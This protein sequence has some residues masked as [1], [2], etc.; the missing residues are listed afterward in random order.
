MARR[1]S[2]QEEQ[3]IVEYM[4]ANPQASVRSVASRF[5]RSRP[6]IDSLRSRYA[7]DKLQAPDPDLEEPRASVAP[8]FD[9]EEEFRRLDEELQRWWDT[10]TDEEKEAHHKQAP[11]SRPPTGGFLD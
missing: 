2:I 8:S 9:I 6:T 11:K 5:S 1:L 7:L 3:E 10:L 4:R